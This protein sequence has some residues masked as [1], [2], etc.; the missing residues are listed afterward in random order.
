[1]GEDGFGE[2]EMCSKD[3]R[4]YACRVY[5]HAVEVNV[6]ASENID[7]PPP[8]ITIYINIK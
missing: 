4:V 8:I 1:M 3:V 5:I 7:S 6:N 2:E